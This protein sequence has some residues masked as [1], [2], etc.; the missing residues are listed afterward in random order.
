[1]SV[2]SLPT[3]TPSEEGVDGHAVERF[4]DALE[5]TEGVEPHG[6]MILRH[7]SVIAA[8]WWSPYAPERLHLLYSLSKSFTSTAVGL[9]AAEGLLSLDDPVVSYFPELDAVI[10]DTRTRS[11]LVRHIAAMSSGHL[12]DTW[13][14]ASTSRPDNPVR[15]FLELRPDRDPGSVFAYNQ[16]ATYTMA[17]ILQRVTGTTVTD[18]LRSRLFDPIGAGEVAWAQLPAGQDVGFTG[19]HAT[20]DTIARLGELYLRNGVW[21]G[22]QVL[23]A[24]WVEQATKQH[25]STDTVVDPAVGDKPDWRQGY[26]FQFWRSRH[27][28]RGDGA[29]GQ[30]C[31]VLPEQDAVVALLGQSSETQAL[32]DLVW[33]ELLP[34]FRD[35]PHSDAPADRCLAE[36]M[37]NLELP[38]SSTAA[39]APIDPVRWTDGAFTPAGGSCTEQPSLEHVSLATGPDGWHLILRELDAELSVPLGSSWRVGRWNGETAPVFASG[40]W[41]D[42]GTLRVE[43]IFVE[44]P[45]RLILTCEL[46]GRTFE[47]A[48]ITAP[49]GS[50]TLRALAA[51]RPPSPVDLGRSESIR[52]A[53]P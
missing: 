53:A 25:I 33:R 46:R 3:S 14:R 19:L 48:W 52:T 43:L 29:Y 22:K 10:T 32:L 8:G 50:S 35:G 51:P 5:A 15:G 39:T 37:A 38:P 17:T 28:Y 7:G 16:S 40:G 2:S 27:G 42:A 11:M 36:R 34:A 23:P 18:Y 30:Y 4:V 49:R 13:Q 44:T 24:G 12:E 26:G 45:H 20:T 21:L 47:A 41:Y 1:V 6:L 9:A 31:L